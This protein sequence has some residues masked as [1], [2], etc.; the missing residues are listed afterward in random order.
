[1]AKGNRILVSTPPGGAKGVTVGGIVSGTP[2]P[3]TVMQIKAA[4]EP[5]NGR[6]TWEA[7]DRSYDAQP[8]T[9]A[10]LLDD[11]LQGRSN[12]TAYASGERCE[13]YFPAM[14]DELNMIIENVAG[15]ADDYAI[16]DYLEVNDGTGKLQD[17]N[18][19]T[20]RNYAA[21]FQCLET[22]TD[23]TADY[24]AHVMYT[25]Q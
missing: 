21:P 12:S 14:G 24:L 10:V 9:I 23:P 22:I 13:I 7:Y 2:K 16:G 3:G 17:A 1:M 18:T 6:F 8:G 4:T 11:P 19:G 5:V 20:T 15:T 25:G